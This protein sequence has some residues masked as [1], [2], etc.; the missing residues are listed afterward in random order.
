MRIPRAIST[1]RNRDFNDSEALEFQGVSYETVG[2]RVNSHERA[3][4]PNVDPG[5][6]ISLLQ[7]VTTRIAD[8]K[9]LID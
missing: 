8:H 4:P 9:S 7:I 1:R 6:Q 5:A 3:E 2:M